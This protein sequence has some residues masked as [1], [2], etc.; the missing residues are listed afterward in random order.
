MGPVGPI[1]QKL[2]LVLILIIRSSGSPVYFF[3]TSAASS[4]V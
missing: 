4:S 1:I 2:S 3:Q